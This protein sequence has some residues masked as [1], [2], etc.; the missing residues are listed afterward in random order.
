MNHSVCIFNENKLSKDFY[1]EWKLINFFFSVKHDAS[2][3]L[4]I[5]CIYIFLGSV[6]LKI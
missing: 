5:F 1:I 2:A 4:I 6:R 3:T